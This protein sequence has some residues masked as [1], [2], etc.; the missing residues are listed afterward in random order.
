MFFVPSLLATGDDTWAAIARGTEAFAVGGLMMCLVTLAVDGTLS[1]PLKALMNL[2]LLRSFGRVS[3]GMYLFHWP[4]VA[5]SLPLLT[6]TAARL[7]PAA[8]V[9][10]SLL[11]IAV[12]TM[13]VYGLASASYRYFEAPFLRSSKGNRP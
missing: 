6:R 9:A 5:I 1:A 4:L 3:Y 2:P 10:F 12:G 13:L 7:P 8:G 11:V